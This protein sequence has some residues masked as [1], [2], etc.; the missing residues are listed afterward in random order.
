MKNRIRVV[1]IVL[2]MS[3]AALVH[4]VEPDVEA[5]PKL[6]KSYSVGGALDLVGT[7]GYLIDPVA[8]TITIAFEELENDQTSGTS[9]D[10]V[11]AIIA[12]VRRL[13]R[14]AAQ[15]QD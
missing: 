10:L 11:V 1:L 6:P 15:A 3:L 8:G 9:G 5:A 12:A 7:V 4:A 14:P 13:R 2:G